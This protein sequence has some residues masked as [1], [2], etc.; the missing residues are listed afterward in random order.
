MNSRERSKSRKRRSGGNA[1]VEWMLVLLPTLGLLTA[2]FDVSYALFC[3][4]TIQNAVREGCRYAITFQTITGYGQDSSIEQTV[5]ADSMGM[6][7]ASSSPQLIFVNYFTQTNPNTPMAAPNGNLPNNIVEV[8][9]QNF[10]LQW[11]VP[12]SGTIID[13]YRSVQPATISVYSSDVLGGYPAGV[14][15]VSR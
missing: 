11:L 2:F 6:V 12:I 15:S 3:W 13:P 10:P 5:A 8:S 14:G 1:L 9:I 7:S 4:S